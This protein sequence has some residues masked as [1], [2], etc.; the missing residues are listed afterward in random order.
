MRQ[1]KDT[2][3]ANETDR[4]RA[5]IVSGAGAYADPWHPFAET[6]QRLSGIMKT[7][8]LDVKITEEVH[9]VLANVAPDVD[10][11]V[12]NFGESPVP[13]HNDISVADVQAGV[14]RFLSKGGAMLVMHA[15]AA[16]F[17][18]NEDWEKLVGA[19]WIPGTTMHPEYGPGTVLIHGGEHALVAGIADFSVDDEFYT[20]LRVAEDVVA[21]A[22]HDYEGSTH[23]LI[24]AREN[25]GARVVYDALGHDRRSFDSPGHRQLLENAVQWL[26]R[27]D[28]HQY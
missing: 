16:S 27:R 4:A 28:R 6:T 2:V 11:L 1:H 14:A 8:G 23:P 15:A 10:L 19:R 22:S 3:G 24:W 12:V 25:A 20:Y 13:G 7:L 18:E 17:A 21:L 9:S 26:L 5:L